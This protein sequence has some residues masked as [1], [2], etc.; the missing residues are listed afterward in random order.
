MLT[1][2][3]LLAKH[4]GR[5]EVHVEADTGLLRAQLN[6]YF[7][8]LEQKASWLDAHR[9]PLRALFLYCSCKRC[10]ARSLCPAS[11]LNGRLRH[12]DQT[13]HRGTHGAKL[14]HRGSR[15]RNAMASAPRT[16][17][18]RTQQRTPLLAGGI[19]THAP[20][21]QRGPCQASPCPCGH[22]PAASWAPHAW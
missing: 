15:R 7:N 13:L 14:C 18:R 19:S 5:S 12:G 3:Q 20:P 16:P 17:L 11:R 8:N 1:R 10:L 9:T 6:A 4:L 22:P 21:S 2:Y